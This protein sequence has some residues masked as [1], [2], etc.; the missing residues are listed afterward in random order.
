MYDTV[1]VGAGPAGMFAAYELI[2]KNPKLKICLIE[3]GKR[4]KDRAKKEVMHGVGGAG[5]YSD[6]KLH[7]TPVLS[8]E[9][10]MDIYSPKEYQKVVDFVDSVFTKFG[11]PED[12][13]PTDM[14][15]VQKLV[16]KCKKHSVHLYVRKTRHVGSDKLPN[17][18][19]NFE[20][21]LVKKGVDL[22][23]ETEVM[24]I[25]TKNGKCVGV[26]TDKEEI[27]AKTVL[28][29]P[30]RTKA[31]WLQEIAVTNKLKT[32]Y[33]KVEVGVRIEFPEGI[34]RKYSDLMYENIFYVQTP[35]F[36]DPMRTFC[37]CPKG[38]VA[39][40]DYEDFVCV[41]GHSNSTHLSENSNFAFVT[42]IKLTEPVEN[43][44][45][46]AKS[47]AILATRLGGG[48]PL[49]QRLADLKS[50]RRSTWERINKSYVTPTLKDVTPGDIAM[51]LPHRIVTNILEGLQMLDK[52]MPGINSGS[53]LLYAP[54]VKFRASRIKTDKY[55]ETELP[56]MFVAGDAAGVSGNILG[57]GASGVIAAK[58]ILKKLGSE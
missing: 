58:G 50:G 45:S 52:V 5:T 17:V 42:E 19:K 25:I 22:K 11:V 8:H 13:Y 32:E 6:G 14:A 26:K 16:D 48:K 24:D 54:E 27:L 1:I 43:T 31:R 47:I 51:A 44:T 3:K 28:L 18:I 29:A 20:D 7:C 15:E 30:G 2:I 34:M 38:L 46:Y 33:Q 35:S 37:P 41:N 49:I 23:T 9:K 57:A 36:D 12:Y 56:S 55:L 10:M 21:S 53:T 40:E 4:V 39:I